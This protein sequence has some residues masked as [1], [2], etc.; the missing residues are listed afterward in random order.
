[1]LDN[2]DVKLSD[3]ILTTTKSLLG[4][5]EEDT[6]FD[7]DIILLINSAIFILS[8][9]G[10]G[11]DN[12]FVKNKNDTY[13]DLLGEGN[14]QRLNGVPMYIYLKTKIGFENALSPSA[15]NTINEQLKELSWYLEYARRQ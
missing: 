8:Q 10:V 15:I 13:S 6:D 7:T 12:F 3:S 11:V 4:I 9:I 1:M 5:S 14:Y 2:N